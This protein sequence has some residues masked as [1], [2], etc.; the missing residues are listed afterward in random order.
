MTDIKGRFSEVKEEKNYVW[1]VSKLSNKHHYHILD[2][3]YH[4]VKQYI[5]LLTALNGVDK[6]EKYFWVYDLKRE[7]MIMSPF[8]KPSLSKAQPDRLWVTEDPSEVYFMGGNYFRM[9]T[10]SFT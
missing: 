7:C 4:P 3:R 10:I 6:V 8:I 1:R 2:V 5:Y 9:W